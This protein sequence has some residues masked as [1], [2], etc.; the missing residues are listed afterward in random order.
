MSKLATQL[1][2]PLWVCV[3]LPIQSRDTNHNLLLF[4]YS[5]RPALA[6]IAGNIIGALTSNLDQKFFI[7]LLIGAGAI[8]LVSLPTLFFAKEQQRVLQEGGS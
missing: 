7:L 1:R 5:Y 4:C 8:V 3:L 6:A 2:L